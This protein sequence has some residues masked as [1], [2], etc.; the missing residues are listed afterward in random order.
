M[1]NGIDLTEGIKLLK[2]YALIWIIVIILSIIIS[3]VLA[4][5]MISTL[6]PVMSISMYYHRISTTIYPNTIRV[7][8]IPPTTSLLAGITGTMIVAIL[9]VIV[10]LI[11]IFMYLIP[12]FSRFAKYSP[13]RYGM[14]Y[15]FVKYGMTFGV[16][17]LF[18]SVVLV[19]VGFATFNIAIAKIGAIILIISLI[20]FM[21]GSIGYWIGLF[22][23]KE[24]TGDTLFMIV[25]IL[26]IIGS[27]LALVGLPGAAGILEIIA[28]VLL[29]AACRSYLKRIGP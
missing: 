11:S 19:V 26:D 28:C 4:I 20:C 7:T 27:V 9:F 5:L 6:G 1:P 15:T 16:L 24:D 3:I 10:A 22:R 29:Y 23:L 25:A 18:L 13:D 12:A 21:I 8:L 2:N 14:A 17:L